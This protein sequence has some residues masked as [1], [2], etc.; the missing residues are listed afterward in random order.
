MN[1]ELI[2]ETCCTE[3]CG[4]VFFLEE[5][6]QQRL[7]STKRTFYCPNG[8]SQNYIG[9][10]DKAKVIRLQNEKNQL[11]REHALEIEKIKKAKCAKKKKK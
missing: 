1:I 8:H 9:E 5:K 6:Y 3:G 4:I 7:V 10:S 2:Q 11:I